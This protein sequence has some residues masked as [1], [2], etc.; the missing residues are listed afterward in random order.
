VGDAAG[1]EAAAGLYLSP[2]WWAAF[3]LGLVVIAL[4][5]SDRLNRP[6]NPARESQRRRERLVALLE[7]LTLGQRSLYLRGYAFYTGLLLAIFMLASFGSAFIGPFI[8]PGAAERVG[9]AEWPLLVALVMV[10]LL[11]GLKPFERIEHKIRAYAHVLAGVPASFHAF[12]DSLLDVRLDDTRLG[13]DIVGAVEAERLAR[14]LRT[15]EAFLGP[16]VFYE[17]FANR[18]AKLFMY[19]AWT[20]G[21]VSWPSY[22]TRQRFRRVE[23]EITPSSLAVIA[24]LEDFVANAGIAPDAAPGSV[25]LVNATVAERWRSL[26]A[27]ADAAADDICALFA[28]YAEHATDKPVHDNPVSAKLRALLETA[29]ERRARRRPDADLIY[30]ALI[31]TSLVAFAIGYLGAMTD[32]LSF[33]EPPLPVAFIYLVSVILLYGP[34]SIVAWDARNPRRQRDWRPAFSGHGL[35]PTRQYLALLAKCYGVTVATL[36]LFTL[37]DLAMTH[38]RQAGVGGIQ[39]AVLLEQFVGLPAE[40]ASDAL[41]ETGKRPTSGFAAYAIG[42]GTLGAAHGVFF[43]LMGDCV[44]KRAERRAGLA[45]TLGHGAALAALALIVAGALGRTEPC[46]VGDGELAAALGLRLDLAMELVAFEM[47]AAFILGVTFSLVSRFALVRMRDATGPSL[48][49]APGGAA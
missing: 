14:L 48:A 31:A 24:D 22:A 37:A 4:F 47:L 30:T 1:P 41:C 46:V 15:A 35:P 44:A 32:M 34:A 9:G 28:L 43:A 5:A 18:A 25:S 2:G 19:Q 11:P 16:G 13:Y 39:A 26:A 3:A 10:G 8:V 33:N 21:V 38:V 49:P 45:L 27:R 17:T 12:T 6:L 23:N 40:G 7:P 29:D 36:A 20:Q 42:Y